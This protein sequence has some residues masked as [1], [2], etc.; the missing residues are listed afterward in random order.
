MLAFQNPCTLAVLI[1]NHDCS[2]FLPHVERWIWASTIYYNIVVTIIIVLDLWQIRLS[3]ATASSVLCIIIDGMDQS[4]F[5]C[6][7]L[8]T[9]PSKHVE[10][11]YR[12][13]LHCSGVLIHGHSF[14]FHIANEDLKKDSTTQAELLFLNL[15][16][17]LET[18]SKLPLILHLQQDN[19]YREGKNQY[20]CAAMILMVVLRVFRATC[21]GFLRTGHSESDI[22]IKS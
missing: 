1:N 21:L 4:K 2:C 16:S 9:R 8:T 3:T 13:T 18:N 10:V 20:I 6:P 15:S 14:S 7:R 19:C 5:R 17:L 11:L 12:P 22:F